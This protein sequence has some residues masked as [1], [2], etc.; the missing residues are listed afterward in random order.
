MH[1]TPVSIGRPGGTAIEVGSGRPL[2]LI[3]GPCVLES[4][5]LARHVAAT[6]QEI[7]SRLGLSYVF[8]ASFDKANRTSIGSYRGPGIDQGL[9]LLWARLRSETA[10]SGR[11]RHPRAPAG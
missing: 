11:L 6:M 8:K 9:E 4:A 7:C 3:A 1:V 10:G 5:D 2:L